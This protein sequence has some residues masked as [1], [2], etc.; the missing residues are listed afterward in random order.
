ME[1]RFAV[2][3]DVDNISYSNASRIIDE[4]RQYG[5]IVIC[6]AY[7][8]WSSE[9]L[10][11]WKNQ[12]VELAIRP[13]MQFQAGKNSSDGLIFIDAMEIRSTSPCPVNAFCLVSTDSDFSSLSTRLREY[14]FYV[15]GIGN[16]NAKRGYINTFHKYI[17]VSNLEIAKQNIDGLSE[18]VKKTEED[19]PLH[20]VS[21]AY[22]DITND[23]AWVYLSSIGLKIRQKYPA[24]DPR[25]FGFEK[26]LDLVRALSSV[27]EIKEDECASPGYLI[28]S[29]DGEKE[30]IQK[31]EDIYIGTI[32]RLIRNYGF[33][34]YEGNSYFFHEI[35]LKGITIKDLAVGSIVGFKIVKLPNP[36]GVTNQEKNGTA[37]EVES[38]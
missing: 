22:W 12:C 29:I 1:Y 19:D 14:G 7:G 27:F 3:I 25:S 17:F 18:M 30:K 9:R 6:R 10:D 23:K 24:F 28:R 37:N 36:N 16:E 15:I 8:D 33:I 34:K 38:K 35:N 20:I 2:L 5:E 11:S 13:M 26:L 31:R 4:V 32:D 21:E